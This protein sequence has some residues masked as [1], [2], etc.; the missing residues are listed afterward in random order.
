MKKI[1][2]IVAVNLSQ[3][4]SFAKEAEETFGI[5]V[6]TTVAKDPN[7]YPICDFVGTE[8]QLKRFLVDMYAVDK[9]YLRLPIDKRVA[10][11]LDDIGLPAW[12]ELCV[13]AD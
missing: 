1:N 6:R 10:N 5:E 12:D 8:D 11:T 13:D 9:R 3:F 4:D 2:L 7:G